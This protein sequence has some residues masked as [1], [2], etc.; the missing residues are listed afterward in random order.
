MD[1]ESF[2]DEEED[3]RR[4]TRKMGADSSGLEKA[5]LGTRGTSKEECSLEGV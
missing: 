1:A 4:G 5:G 3:R 2:Q